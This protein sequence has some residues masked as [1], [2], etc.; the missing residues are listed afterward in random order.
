[1]RVVPPDQQDWASIKNPQLQ[2]EQYQ[3]QLAALVINE[4]VLAINEVVQE[5]VAEQPFEAEPKRKRKK[6]LQE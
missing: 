2:K 4:E 5:E 3:E 1:M 6:Q